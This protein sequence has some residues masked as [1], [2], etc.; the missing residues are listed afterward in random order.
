MRSVILRLGHRYSLNR[1]FLLSSEGQLAFGTADLHVAFAVE[2][3]TEGLVA[4][5][6]LERLNV[7]VHLLDVLLHISLL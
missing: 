1:S 7:L 4:I 3:L 5:C 6:T 2:L